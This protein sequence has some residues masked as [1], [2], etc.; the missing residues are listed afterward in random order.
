MKKNNKWVKFWIIGDTEE[1]EGDKRLYSKQSKWG[2][3]TK[4]FLSKNK[5]FL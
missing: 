5:L 2:K 1:V 3:A 4:I